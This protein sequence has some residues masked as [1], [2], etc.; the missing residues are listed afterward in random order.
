MVPSRLFGTS[1][2]T[3]A[4]LWWTVP[5]AGALTVAV[6]T[7]QAPGLSELSSQTT[8]SAVSSKALML[9]RTALPVLVTWMVTVMSEPAGTGTPGVALASPLMRFS[10]V[11][12]GSSGTKA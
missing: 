11:I 2:V 8:F 9:L 3:V 5:G 1:A 12:A 4:V 6:Q 7:V 10:T